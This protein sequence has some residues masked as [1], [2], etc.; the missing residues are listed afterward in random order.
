VIFAIRMVIFQ[1]RLTMI[2]PQVMITNGVE[3]DY[4]KPQ[5]AA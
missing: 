5:V 4:A 1:F 2:R 3:I